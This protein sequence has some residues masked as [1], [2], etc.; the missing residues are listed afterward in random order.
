MAKRRR[1]QE[2]PLDGNDGETEEE[3]QRKLFGQSSS[4][5]AGSIA[6]EVA[7]AGEQADAQLQTKDPMVS[8]GSQVTESNQ[9][10]SF[11]QPAWTDPDE[12]AVG[13]RLAKH[14]RTRKLRRTD[15]EDGLSGSQYAIR[16]REQHHK[17]KQRTQ[18]ARVPSE[19]SA[20]AGAT[21]TL[22]G[23]LR[24]TAAASTQ[25]ASTDAV[26][27]LQS[28]PLPAAQLD[29][30]RVRDL[31]AEE[32]S[33]S[34]LTSVCFHAN[35]QLALSAGLDRRVRLFNVD[36][37]S[38]THVE[39]LFLQDM[40]ITKSRFAGHSFIVAA[41]NRPFLH[42][43]DMETGSIERIAN[44]APQKGEAC[45]NF[46]TGPPESR[47]SHL[48]AA[49]GAN[50]R[51]KLLSLHT[52]QRVGTLSSGGR[53]APQVSFGER[54]SSLVAACSDGYLRVFDLRTMRC[55]HE[56]IDDGSTGTSSPA[57]VASDG[58]NSTIAVGQASG[59][60]N[61]YTNPKEESSKPSASLYNLTTTADVLALSN[62]KQMAAV[63]SSEKKDS[64]RIVH[65][66]SQTVF[67]NWPTSR[68][69]VHYPS[70]VAFSPSSGFVSIA[71]A[72]GKALL[73]RLSHFSSA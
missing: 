10:A 71:N 56:F 63:A 66:P 60:V 68:T 64:V 69:P 29:S 11:Q 15:A 23:V 48:V 1:K 54:D 4:H 5:V 70:D 33:T 35:A 58:S 32:P 39:T 38:N 42:L 18:W 45:P 31:N 2:N 14:A 30:V 55:C 19:R 72:R 26:D 50:G 28:R 59:V 51:V 46:A 6:A 17:M 49:P 47:M 7:L 37:S 34:A 43:A 41:G 21:H 73:Y 22:D 27:E 62:C 40:P 65:L 3:L 61:L 24:T 20:R 53:K 25:R 36:G 12:A 9:S 52:K 57:S 8:D 13:V 44:A 16:L 67:S